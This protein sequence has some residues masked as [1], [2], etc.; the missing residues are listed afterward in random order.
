MIRES[1]CKYESGSDRSSAN[2]PKYRESVAE[3]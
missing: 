1:D 3:I 2:I